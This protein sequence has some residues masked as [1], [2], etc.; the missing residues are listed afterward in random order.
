V[1]VTED[2]AV[3]MCLHGYVGPVG[4]ALWAYLA[5]C[6]QRALTDAEKADICRRYLGWKD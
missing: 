1:T 5:I 6:L 3:T 2:R 4:P